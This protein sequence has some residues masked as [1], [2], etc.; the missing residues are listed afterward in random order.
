MDVCLELS[1][2]IVEK[3]VD[4][5][6][7]LNVTAIINYNNYQ[8]IANESHQF[9]QQSKSASVPVTSTTGSEQC[10]NSKYDINSTLN[11][12][13]CHLPQILLEDNDNNIKSTH[14]SDDSNSN[15]NNSPYVSHLIQIDTYSAGIFCS[16]LSL[17]SPLCRHLK[18]IHHYHNDIPNYKDLGNT[19]V[20][21]KIDYSYLSSASRNTSA[22]A[23]ATAST[24]NSIGSSATASRGT[25]VS[26]AA[27]TSRATSISTVTGASTFLLQS[28]ILPLS[29]CTLSENIQKELDALGVIEN[30][31]GTADA[32]TDSNDDTI[33]D[34]E[35][36]R[37]DKGSY[38]DNKIKKNNHDAY[39]EKRMGS[40]DNKADNHGSDN[41][42]SNTID[43]INN[44]KVTKNSENKINH[45]KDIQ[46]FHVNNDSTNL[47]I[48][49]FDLNSK[50]KEKK[51]I[52]ERISLSYA[53]LNSRFEDSCFLESTIVEKRRITERMICE[54]K[55]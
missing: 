37:I 50:K 45:I 16:L 39:S 29:H 33:F 4:C 52:F 7:P 49:D 48:N 21:N 55:Y 23:S 26:T 22:G 43:S 31:A 1:Q 3:A 2:F 15:I 20:K 6:F 19:Q 46:K 35:I 44:G 17:S 36:W 25:S 5:G 10:D 30:G 32:R 14:I 11:L 28:R 51:E 38:P 9:I 8:S 54:H 12:D 24:R 41:K 27:G 42:I 53:K 18:A 47:I 13:T 40:I 34:S